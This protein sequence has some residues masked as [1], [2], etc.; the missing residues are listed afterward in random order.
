[1]TKINA[2]QLALTRVQEQPSAVT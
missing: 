1:M 2:I